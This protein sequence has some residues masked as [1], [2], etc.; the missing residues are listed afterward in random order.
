MIEVA[1]GDVYR[2]MRSNGLRFY[3]AI[4]NQYFL[5]FSLDFFSPPRD[6]A[7]I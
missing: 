1:S 3:E 7:P 6:L 2:A 5:H 4:I